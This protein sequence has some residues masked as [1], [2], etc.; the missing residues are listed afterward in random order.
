MSLA[1]GALEELHRIHRQLTDVSERIAAGP[2]QIK[3]AE[4]AVAKADQEV[5]TSKEAYKKARM[6]ADEKQLQLKQ[7][8][9]KLKDLQGKLNAAESNREYPVSYTHLRAHET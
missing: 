6:T 3:A 7:R 4:A 2:K 9:A 8:E 5:T 1:P